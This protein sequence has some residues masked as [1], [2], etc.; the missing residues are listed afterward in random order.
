MA[1]REKPGPRTRSPEDHIEQLIDEA[2]R[3]TFPASDPPA[4]AVD[5]LPAKDQGPAR[6]NPRTAGPSKDPLP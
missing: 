5:V 2:L 1:G 3:E 4:P 6:R